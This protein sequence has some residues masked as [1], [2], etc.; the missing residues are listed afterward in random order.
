[1]NYLYKVTAANGE[2]VY[3]RAESVRF[4]ALCVYHNGYRS[5]YYVV[6]RIDVMLSKSPSN[7]NRL[8]DVNGVY[9]SSVMPHESIENGVFVSIKTLPSIEDVENRIKQA[10]TDSEYQVYLKSKKQDENL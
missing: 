9:V 6:E 5:D 10:L 4:A 3:T 8:N 7:I 2:V 1:M